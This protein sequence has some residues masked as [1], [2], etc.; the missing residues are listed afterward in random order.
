MYEKWWVG[1]GV[2][3]EICKDAI[4]DSDA[5]CAMKY[6]FEFTFI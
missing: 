6:L 4:I 5:G 3:I 2:M 1:G